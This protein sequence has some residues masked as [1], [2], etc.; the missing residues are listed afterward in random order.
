MS[1]ISW[2]PFH[3]DAIDRCNGAMPTSGTFAYDDTRFGKSQSPSSTGV[4]YMTAAQ[5]NTML[6]NSEEMSFAFWIYVP[7]DAS[8]SSSIFG[9]DGMS[10][11]P[12]RRFAIYQYPTPND[13]HLS[14]QNSS[15]TVQIG[16]VVSGVLPSAAWTHC[17]IVYKSGVGAKI[18]INGAYST[19]MGSGI[20]YGA[21]GTFTS[22]Y[23]LWKG[24]S[25][26]Y[27]NDCRIYDHALS[28]REIKELARGLA[29]KLNGDALQTGTGLK[30]AV[31]SDIFDESGFG[32]QLK[33]GGTIYADLSDARCESLVWE[34]NCA[35]Y[36]ACTS[37]P[38]M[39]DSLTYE[40]WIYPTATPTTAY[41]YIISQGRDYGKG[42]GSSLLINTSNKVFFQIGNGT[43]SLRL[44]SPNAVPLN[45]W[46]HVAAT[47]D[48]S[49]ARL[50]VNGAQVAASTDVTGQLAFGDTDNQALVIGKMGSYYV[51]TGTYFPFTGKMRGIKVYRTVLSAEDISM[52]YREGGAIDR[53]GGLFVGSAI[54]GDYNASFGKRKTLATRQFSEIVTYKDGSKWL[55]LQHHDV[56]SGTRFSS[57]SDVINKACYISDD[58]WSCFPVMEQCDHGDSYEFLVVQQASPTGG[59]A[60]YRWKQSVSP[61]S[62]TY[63]QT[64]YA[65]ITPVENVS[66][67]MGG[68]YAT[69]SYGSAFTFNNGTNGNWYGCGNINAY[70]GGL[71]GYN[72]VTVKGIQDVFIRVYS[73]RFREFKTGVSASSSINCII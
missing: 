15:G 52:D 43:T 5:A 63:D 31:V 21:S 14:W 57:A 39:T 65:N 62:A 45:A 38:K 68:M 4:V 72:W 12:Y 53:N 2:F 22:N 36:L 3:G 47:Y 30:T 8:S 48:A 26:R 42:C 19:T 16:T 46:T 23:P 58:A 20:T 27:L 71:P 29:F 67:P 59:V 64:T 56:A 9:Y 1:L 73:G 34:G 49:T 18:Y 50:Y 44:G 10:A 61:M 40:C 51:N 41:G 54:E 7:S 66:S 35:N 32:W 55:Q 25:M 69:P 11:F 33:K 37:F 60:C 28:L 70:Y 17:A 6:N 13:L 24:N